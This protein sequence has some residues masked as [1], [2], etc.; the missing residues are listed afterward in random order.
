[1]ERLNA[2]I[3]KFVNNAKN[4]CLDPLSDAEIQAVARALVLKK[5]DPDKKL[6]SEATRNWNEIATGRLQFDRRQKEAKTLLNITKK[7][8]LE[9]WDE[10]V[11]GIKGGR[12]MLVSEVI[13]KSGDASSRTPAKS[14][15]ADNKLGIDDVDRYRMDREQKLVTTS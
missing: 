8:V 11:L 4:A 9:Y 1:V 7:D 6:A 10:I 5:T 2:E 12:R 3:L 14:Y 13:P 15:K